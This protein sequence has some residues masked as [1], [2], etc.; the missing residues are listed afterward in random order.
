MKSTFPENAILLVYCEDRKGLVTAV[1]QFIRDHNGNILH[2]DQHVDA[3]ANVFLMRVEWSLEGFDL[4]RA[5]LMDRM[6]VFAMPF[7][8]TWSIHYTTDRPAMALFVSKDAHCLYDLLARHEAG[9]LPA[10]IP[11]IVSNHE[12]LRPV[13]DRFDIPYHVFPITKDTKRTQEEKE[14]ALLAEHKVELVVMARYMQILSST[15]VE[16]YPQRVIN[17]HHSFLPA[18][19]GAKPYHSA[20]ARGVKIIGATAHYATKD[21]DEGP[22]IAQDV[23]RVSHRD[24]LRDFIREGRDAEK[25]VLARAVYLH[26][27]RRVL[28]YNNKTVVFE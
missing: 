12:T 22:I 13:A 25:V 14:L 5:A 28:V 27:G 9:E 15:F 6:E 18:F 1:T 7:G 24:S 23:I 11:L 3:E 20:Y 16:A 19:A 8:M 26:L 17:I 2:L 4:E 10:R 21:L